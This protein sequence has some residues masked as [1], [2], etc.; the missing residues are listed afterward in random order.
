[1]LKRLA[2]GRCMNGSWL[3]LTSSFCW[4]R[5]FPGINGRNTRALGNCRKGTLTDYNNNRKTGETNAS[6]GSVSALQRINYAQQRVV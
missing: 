5:Q 3:S 4:P 6:L 2:L 1:M